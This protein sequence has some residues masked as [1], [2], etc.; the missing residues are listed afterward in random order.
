MHFKLN[1]NPSLKVRCERIEQWDHTQLSGVPNS[2]SSE[3]LGFDLKNKIYVVIKA[4]EPQEGIGILT[5][6]A[7][8]KRIHAAFGLA[9]TD[10]ARILKVKRATYYNWLKE[11][12]DPDSE[13]TI[14][15]IREFFAIAE[16]VS[17]FNEFSYGRKA[18]TYT[19][20]G[21][22]LMGL[23]CED[24]FDA[25]KIVLLCQKLTAILEKRE[26]N[27][28]QVNVASS[29]IQKSYTSF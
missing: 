3:A 15:R 19:C 29:I 8:L 18:K 27:S 2:S 1:M 11:K 23:L 17:Q 22:T 21:D 10:Y 28:R 24:A 7:M 4:N 20:N 14:E 9:V 26:A 5:I 16:Q 25:R 6:S 12:T 13:E